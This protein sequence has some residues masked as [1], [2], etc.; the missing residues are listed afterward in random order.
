[1]WQAP[2]ARAAR[3]DHARQNRLRQR[4]RSHEI[5]IDDAINGNYVEPDEDEPEDDFGLLDD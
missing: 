3:G 5:D 4:N 2:A 1:M